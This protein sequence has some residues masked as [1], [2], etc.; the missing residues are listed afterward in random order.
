MRATPAVPAA[1][2]VSTATAGC[3][4]TTNSGIE[5]TT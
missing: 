3:P 5:I 2:W 4:F 1:D